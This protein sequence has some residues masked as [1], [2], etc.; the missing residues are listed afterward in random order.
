MKHEISYG[1]HAITVYRAYARPL[2]VA[3][4]PESAFTGRHN[5]LLAA[6][7]TVDVLGG[8]FLPA[9]TEGDNSMVVA[10]D[11]MKNFTYAMALEYGGATL[12]G[13]AAFL[14]RRFLDTYPQMERVRVHCEEIPFQ[15]LSDKLLSQAGGDRAV[16]DLDMS[17]EGLLAPASAASECDC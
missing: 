1:K 13:L 16:V 15:E 12:E 6:S 14:A 17:R 9:Y 2:R 8:N 4:I 11:T 7:V 5:A 10:T 3:P